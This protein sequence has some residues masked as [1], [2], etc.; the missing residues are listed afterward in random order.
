MWHRRLHD[1][2]VDARVV[3]VQSNAKTRHFRRI[4]SGGGSFPFIRKEVM[5][6]L[7]GTPFRRRAT[8]N[9]SGATIFTPERQ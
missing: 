7:A 5:A 9:K 1:L 2:L 4:R 6:W 8:W 3:R